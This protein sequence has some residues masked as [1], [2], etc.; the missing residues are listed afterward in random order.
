MLRI[1]VHDSPRVLTFRL[2]GRVEG[3]WV[4]VLENCWERNL[5][6]AGNAALRVD[7][8]GVTFI[9]PAGKTVLARAHA[10]GAELVAGD[11]LTSAIVEEITARVRRPNEVSHE[12]LTDQ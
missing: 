5:D 7:L 11:C 9:D 12:A 6:T 8:S 4:A 1:T 10:R 2:E 3:P